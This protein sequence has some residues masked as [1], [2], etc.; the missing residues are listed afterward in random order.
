MRIKSTYA[1][2]YTAVGEESRVSG[3]LHKP[4]TRKGFVFTLRNTGLTL[5][6]LSDFS[7]EK[8]TFDP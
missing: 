4:M 7:K 3:G 1:P 5:L 2:L 6:K 8:K